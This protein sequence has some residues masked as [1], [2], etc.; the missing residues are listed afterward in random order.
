MEQEALELIIPHGPKLCPQSLTQQ[1]F[2]D[3]LTSL[4]DD[5][6]DHLVFSNTAWYSCPCVV[7]VGGPASNRIDLCTNKILGK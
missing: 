6:N 7:R 1:T 2:T 4:R 5:L 3:V